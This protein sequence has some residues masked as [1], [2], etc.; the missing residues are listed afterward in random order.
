MVVF[1]APWRKWI[2]RLL[3]KI[4][5]WIV[6]SRSSAV[7]V[8]ANYWLR[9]H[10]G[11]FHF[12][13]WF[14][15]IQHKL[16]IGNFTGKL[17]YA[18]FTTS[19]ISLILT[20]HCLIN[21]LEEQSFETHLC[22]HLFFSHFRVSRKQLFLESFPSLHTILEEVN[23]FELRNGCL[24]KIIDAFKICQICFCAKMVYPS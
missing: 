8:K 10:D 16:S 18:Y 21:L 24:T 9:L 15:I 4:V 12:S 23:D 13:P 19:Q 22:E 2:P 7:K 20:W 17:L 3:G 6:S 5:Q 1:F 11:L 14:W